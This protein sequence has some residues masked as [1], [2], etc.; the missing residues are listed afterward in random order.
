MPYDEDFYQKIRNSKRTR[1]FNML[2]KEPNFGSILKERSRRYGV[3]MNTPEGPIYLAVRFRGEVYRNGE[4]SVNL[5]ESENKAA[6]AIDY[7]HILTFNAKGVLKIGVFEIETGDIYLADLQKWKDAPTIDYT[8]KRGSLQ[9]KLLHSEMDII[10]GV[11]KY[12]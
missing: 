2:K 8:H 5:A 6:W 3:Y 1:A 11:A 4:E 9:K 7:G 12:T 10:R